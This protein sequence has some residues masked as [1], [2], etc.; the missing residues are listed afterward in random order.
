MNPKDAAKGLSALSRHANILIKGLA[1]HGAGFE[2]TIY[3]ESLNGPNIYWCHKHSGRLNN[4]IRFSADFLLPGCFSGFVVTSLMLG[5]KIVP[6][7]TRHIAFDTRV[8]FSKRPHTFTRQ[9]RSI[10]RTIP[11]KIMDNIAPICIEATDMILEHIH[12]TEYWQRYDEALPQV[13]KAV[14]GRYLLDEAAVQ[15][16][17]AFVMRLVQTGELVPEGA[18]L[19]PLN[20]HPINC[21]SA[22]LL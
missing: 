1:W 9:M 7:Y 12:N 14:F 5:L 21:D 13:Q 4:L 11:L 15:R 8:L 16:A 17:G 10:W 18:H 3:Q 20:T 22:A 6:V 2:D 19:A